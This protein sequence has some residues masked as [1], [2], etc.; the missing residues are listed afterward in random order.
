MR[1]KLAEL[2][3]LLYGFRKFI[4]WSVLFLVAIIL[5]IQG[6]VDGSQFVDLIKATFLGFVAGNSTEHFMNTAKEYIASKATNN[7]SDTP[8]VL[9]TTEEEK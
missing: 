3:D 1:Q 9:E 4:A 2:F 8:E 5:R 7:S 6:F